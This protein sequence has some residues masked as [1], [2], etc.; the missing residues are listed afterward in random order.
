[1]EYLN[2]HLTIITLMSTLPFVSLIFH[3]SGLSNKVPRNCLGRL[4]KFIKVKKYCKIY[5]PTVVG[6]NSMET[7]KYILHELLKVYET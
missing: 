6:Y 4:N 1:M 5:R 7:L 3:K 2:C